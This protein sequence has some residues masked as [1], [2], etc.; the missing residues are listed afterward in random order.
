MRVHKSRVLIIMFLLFILLILL[1]LSSCRHI[2]WE[3]KEETMEGRTRTRTK[4]RCPFG[5]ITY[6]SAEI[7]DKNKVGGFQ[8]V[9]HTAT[10]GGPNPLHN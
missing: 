2:S 9:S 10:P 5:T 1:H 6:N 8:A 3:E 4:S 7:K